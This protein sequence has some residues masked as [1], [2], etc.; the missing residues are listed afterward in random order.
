MASFQVEVVLQTADAAPAASYFS[1]VQIWQRDV[2]K[3]R[4]EQTALLLAS[5]Q[6]TFWSVMVVP[7]G[8]RAAVIGVPPLPLIGCLS[9]YQYSLTTVTTSV[10]LRNSALVV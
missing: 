9:A 3:V 2:S 6:K 1:A 7:A 8:Q 10:L 4:V 5:V